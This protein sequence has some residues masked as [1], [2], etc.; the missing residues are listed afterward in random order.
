M[1]ERVQ[2]TP[3]KYGKNPETG[4]HVTQ[5]NKHDNSIL[6]QQVAPT[7]KQSE[8]RA[9]TAISPSD[10]VESTAAPGNVSGFTVGHVH[11]HLSNL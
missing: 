7:H 10:H 5:P 3:P 2:A 6:A 8:K 11:L 1:T 9:I 4:A